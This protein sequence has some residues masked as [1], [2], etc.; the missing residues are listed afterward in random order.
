MLTASFSFHPAGFTAGLL[1]IPS[2]LRFSNGRRCA[3][4]PDPDQSLP[5]WA[6]PQAKRPR[7]TASSA[8]GRIRDFQI[9]PIWYTACACWQ[10]ELAFWPATCERSELPLEAGTAGKAHQTGVNHRCTPFCGI[11]PQ[12]LPLPWV[13]VFGLKMADL[14]LV[15]AG[16]KPAAPCTDTFSA[17][18]AIK[19]GIFRKMPSID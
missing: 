13:R 12:N 11:A 7:T 9:C 2:A 5:A 18:K 6:R 1:P 10:K 17:E 14:G 15:S 8:S 19:T 4:P 3:V 16:A